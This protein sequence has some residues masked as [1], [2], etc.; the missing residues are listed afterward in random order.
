[1]KLFLLAALAAVS[2]SAQT[3]TSQGSNSPNIQNVQGDVN[4]N[5]PAAPAPAKPQERPLTPLEM[6][7]SKLLDKTVRLEQARITESQ[8]KITEAQK[9][10]AQMVEEACGS[11]GIAA[12]KWQTECG[13]T[14]GINEDDKP[15]LDQNGYPVAARVWKR[16]P[17]PA[18]VKP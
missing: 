14:N 3:Q 8:R 12:A 16:P 1:M 13:F 15:I 4:T 9:Q 5:A 10:Y 17:P 11:I 2:L 7:N 18:P 6:A